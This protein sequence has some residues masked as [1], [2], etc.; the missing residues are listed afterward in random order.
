MLDMVIERLHIDGDKPVNRAL[1]SPDSSMLAVMTAFDVDESGCRL[2]LYSRS[3]VWQLQDSLSFSN[4]GEKE[5]IFTHLLNRETHYNSQFTV[6]P[7]VSFSPDSRRLVIAE[8]GKF[9]VLDV[10]GSISL[11][12]R[13]AERCFSSSEDSP[14]FSSALFSPDGRTLAVSYASNVSEHHQ[15]T[16]DLKLTHFC[17]S[18]NKGVL[19]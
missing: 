18:L 14:S 9:F 17:F 1:Y 5:S 3:P 10:D 15:L 19:L 7:S 8:N 16:V 12:N 13:L 2:L 4:K 11:R 6:A